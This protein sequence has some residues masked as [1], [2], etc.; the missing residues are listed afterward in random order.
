MKWTKWAFVAL[1]CVCF[2]GC[3]LLNPAQQ[4]E[5]M[6]VLNQMKA[7]GSI[8]QAQYDAMVEMLLN[9]SQ[10][11]WW[12]QFATVAASAGLAWLGVRS[13]LPVIGRGA[14]TQKVGLP[15]AK[16]VN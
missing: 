12:Q 6:Q 1:V 3:G 16:I 13:N 15:V 9:G 10:A 5:A 8:T 4:S 11:A 2:A 14:P 7:N